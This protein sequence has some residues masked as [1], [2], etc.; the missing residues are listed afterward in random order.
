LHRERLYGYLRT[1]N[2]VVFVFTGAWIALMG[3][4]ISTRQEPRWAESIIYNI[5]NTVFIFLLAVTTVDLR[6]RGQRTVVVSDASL[7]I[8]R[9]N[10]TEYFTGTAGIL[11]RAFLRSQGRTL[12]CREIAAKAGEDTESGPNSCSACLEARWKVT[13]CKHYRNIY[14]MTL[15]IKRM[16]ETLEIGTIVSPQDRSR[17]KEDGWKLRLFVG[18]RVVPR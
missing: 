16:L 3:Y 11:V 6:I 7:H 12:T 1:F 10:F 14:N 9:Y 8:D 13:R 17:V 4:A 5:Y 18:V 2:L 15:D